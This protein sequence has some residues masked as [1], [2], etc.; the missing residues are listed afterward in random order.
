ML[1][2]Y[3]QK[4]REINQTFGQFSC[5]FSMGDSNRNKLFILDIFIAGIFTF[6]INVTF[7]YYEI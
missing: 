5:N 1:F 7:I 2:K 3:N 6:S 4:V